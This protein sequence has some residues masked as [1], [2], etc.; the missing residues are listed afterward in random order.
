MSRLPLD[1]VRI[2][3]SPER[4]S[5]VVS[6]GIFRKRVIASRSIACPAAM[7]EE[8]SW[9]PALAGLQ[10]VL[11]GL[12]ARQQ[13]ATV[14]LS[15]HFVHYTLLPGDPQLAGDE[16]EQAYIRLHFSRTYGEQA[17]HWAM[18]MSAAGHG[19]QQVASAVEQAF[20]DGLDHEIRVAGLELVSIQPY[21]MAQFNHWR[22]QLDGGAVWFVLAESGKVCLAQLE[23][24]G[25]QGLR[26]IKMH[27]G[28]TDEVTYLLDREI[29]LADPESPPE[30]V[31]LCASA[32]LE[33]A[34]RRGDDWPPVRWLPVAEDTDETTARDMP[35][36][37]KKEA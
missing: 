31:Y 20:L 18:R 32:A 34:L 16:E 30:I 26:T 5:A 21:L 36:A 19:G 6:R 22:H 3:L 12:D 24:G 33:S 8:A 28:M 2:Q 10:A 25:W 29:V 17:A 27:T 23:H 15:N 37:E 4:V 11:S 14:V 35:A 9:R 1:H 7:P 13:H